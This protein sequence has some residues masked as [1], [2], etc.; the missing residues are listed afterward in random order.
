MADIMGAVGGIAFMAILAWIIRIFQTNRRILKLAGMQ[1]E[2]QTRLID[3]FD[4]AEELR[5][6]LDSEGGKQ[7]LK[8]TPVE[9][10]SPY[11]RILGSIQA[12]V[13]LTLGGLAVFLIRNHVPGDSG[14]DFAMMFLGALGIAIGLGFLISATASFWL[15][16]SWGLI[17]GKDD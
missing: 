9:N 5:T 14:E 3:K 2:M 8:A 16:K 11:G 4:S 6:Y 15:S 10:A 1:V 7:L 17:N 13:I 12:G